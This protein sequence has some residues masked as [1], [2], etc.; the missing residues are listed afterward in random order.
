MHNYCHRNGLEYPLALL[1]ISLQCKRR[2]YQCTFNDAVH[3]LAYNEVCLTDVLVHLHSRPQHQCPFMMYDDC[4]QPYQC[5]NLGMLPEQVTEASEH[6]LKRSRQVELLNR[7]ANA[8]VSGC[9]LTHTIKQYKGQNASAVLKTE[10][11]FAHEHMVHFI[12]GQCGV[13]QGQMLCH[14]RHVCIPQS[15]MHQMLTSE[16]WAW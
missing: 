14:V 1:D 2:A 5:T 4:C 6:H 12:G 3:F 9:C 10:L 7:Q 15:K 13:L 11:T 8:H 16:S